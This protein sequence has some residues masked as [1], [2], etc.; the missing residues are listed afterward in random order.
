VSEWRRHP[1]RHTSLVGAGADGDE[2]GPA[3][4]PLDAWLPP[5]LGAWPPPVEGLSDGAARVHIRGEG[6]APDGDTVMLGG[7][8]L[9]RTPAPG[10][11]LGPPVRPG[12]QV[13][14]VRPQPRYRPRWRL[15]L[16]GAGLAV[17]AAAGY[18]G[19]PPL[20]SALGTGPRVA[21]GICQLPI[22]SSAAIGAG[23]GS[24]P[25]QPTLRGTPAPSSPGRTAGTPSTAPVVAVPPPATATGSAPPP[26]LQVSYTAIPAGPGFTGQITVVNQGA[27]AVFGWQLVVALPGDTVSAVQNAEFTDD[28]GVLF[29][30]P[31][32]YDLSVTPGNAVTISIYA[33]GPADIPAECSFNDVACH[34]PG[35]IRDSLSTVTA[36]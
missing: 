7:L 21:C 3:D 4:R 17:L 19:A 26:T 22:P 5:G 24:S 12:P 33:S 18:L 28:D 29:M 2:P 25:A 20:L 13:E 15:A 8:G 32:P 16:A 34:L 36:G 1:G 35:T 23:G 9:F 27:A 11:G 31:A 14:W 6:P 30:T 10:T